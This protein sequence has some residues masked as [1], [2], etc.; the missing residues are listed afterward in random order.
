MGLVSSNSL[1]KDGFAMSDK[2]AKED[3]TVTN[4]NGQT[5]LVASKGSPLPED[6]DAAKERAG[7]ATSCRP[8]SG[9]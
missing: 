2:L 3:I 9:A 6:L 8:G 4:V 1:K 5:V 7:R